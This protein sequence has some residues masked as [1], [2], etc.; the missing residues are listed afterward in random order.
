M[1]YHN[2]VSTASGLG[3]QVNVA[4][5]P[6]VGASSA[7]PLPQTSSQLGTCFIC[8]KMGHLKKS[9]PCMAEGPVSYK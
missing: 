5:S 7:M 2:A 9:I 4:S 8:G 3:G 1:N 6:C